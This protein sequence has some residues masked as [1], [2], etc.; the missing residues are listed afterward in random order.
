[1]PACAPY[2]VPGHCPFPLRHP[3]S[4]SPLPVSWLY[5]PSPGPWGQ[6]APLHSGERNICLLILHLCSHSLLGSSN[7]MRL[8]EGA[9]LADA[10]QSPGLLRVL[11]TMQCWGHP[12]LSG[13][14]SALCLLQR[15]STRTTRRGRTCKPLCVRSPKVRTCGSASLVHP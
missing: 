1:M 6:G 4:S 14:D 11:G 7:H 15:V 13:P 12:R 5:L 3:C 8:G 9:Y 2:S 10:A